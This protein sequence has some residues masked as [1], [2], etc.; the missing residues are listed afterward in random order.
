MRSGLAMNLDAMGFVMQIEEEF[1]IEI[2]KED[3]E[4]LGTVGALCEYI[5]KRS[6]VPGPDAVWKAVQRIASE[7]FQIPTEEIKL[8]SR[9]VGDLKID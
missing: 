2:L 5:R 8:T 4:L 9:W 7:E 1:E 6:S 3:Y